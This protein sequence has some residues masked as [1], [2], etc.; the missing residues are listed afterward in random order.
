VER[1][2]VGSFNRKKKR[3][4]NDE[5]KRKLGAFSEKTSIGILNWSYQ[6]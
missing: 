3:E 6:V 1:G 5:L 4:K 2:I